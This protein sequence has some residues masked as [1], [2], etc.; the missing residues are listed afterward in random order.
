MHITEMFR[1]LRGTGH[2]L[3]VPDVLHRDR[4]APRIHDGA[5]CVVDLTAA[6]PS[7]SWPATT[8]SV[9]ATGDLA[10]WAIA[11][12][13]VDRPGQCPRIHQGGVPNPAYQRLVRR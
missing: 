10:N 12:E 3:D 7:P 6:S 9:S 4:L 1:L 11:A 8:T 2:F 5:F 13:A